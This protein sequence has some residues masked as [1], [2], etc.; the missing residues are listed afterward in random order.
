MNSKVFSRDGVLLLEIGEENRDVVQIKDIPERI[1]GA[2]LAAEDDNFYAHHG[3]DYYGLARAFIANIKGGGVV[4]GG[5]TITQQVAKL[6]LLSKEKT[7]SRKVKDI[8]LAQKIEKQFSK[9]EILFLYL[10]QVYLGGGYYGVKA[11]L[12]GYFDKDLKEAS[13]AESALIAGLLVA[14]GKYSPYVNPKFAK[15]RQRYV[16]KRMHATKKITDEEYE[17]ALI[18]PITMKIRNVNEMKGG[19]FTDWV[20]QQLLES[21][22][23]EEFLNKGYNVVTTIDWKLQEK[24]QET[25]VKRTKELDKRQGFKGKNRNIPESDQKQILKSH[26]EKIYKEA[27]QFFTFNAEGENIYEYHLDEDE[28]EKII[29]K[30]DDKKENLNTRHKGIVE[31]GSSEDDKLIQFIKK[32]KSYQAIVTNVSDSAKMIYAT[33]AGVKVMI[34]LDG[35]SWAHERKL[36]ENERYFSLITKPSTILKPGDEIQVLIKGDL[37]SPQKYLSSEFKKKYTDPQL[38]KILAQEKFLLADL[39][40]EAEVEGALVAIDPNNGHVLALVGGGNFNKSQFN[41]AVQAMRQPGSSFK[42]FIYAAGLENGFA[43]SSILLDTPQS[44]G[45]VDDSLSWKPKNYDNEFMGQMTYRKA[46]EVSRNIP[47]IKILQDIGIQNMNDFSNRLGMQVTLPKD[48]SIALGSFGISLVE[49]ARAYTIFPNA[50]KISPLQTI[51]SIKDSSGKKYP[52]PTI[53]KNTVS[54][55]KDEPESTATQPSNPF[56]QNL[57]ESQV[58]DKRLAYIMTQLLR[59][60]ITSGTATAARG[61][62][63]NIAGKTGT[64][65]NYVDALFV[66]FS[67][68]IVVATWTGFDDNRPMGY[69]ETGGKTALPMWMDFMETAIEKLGA[70]EFIYPEG[71][72]AKNINKN[73]GK[74]APVGSPESITEYF[75]LG[76]ESG[77]KAQTDPNAPAD[78]K[79][80]EDDDYYINQ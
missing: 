8:I 50:G 41:R 7:F 12:R 34:P 24:A 20:R 61:L 36:D 66:G 26:R 25:V 44:L 38:N 43:A 71:V 68:K 40:Q 74:E 37:D 28:F 48:M 80:I 79:T 53:Y 9:E 60:V 39:D 29:D 49:L 22:G 59:G 10:N 13:V 31:I 5:S 45:G 76:H 78:T 27:S 1:V 72:V 23:T 11:A 47:T 56:L 58:Y 65:N 77:I 42:P 46:L 70:P 33:L 2:F 75:V 17:K 15:M 69:G 54:K 73:T 4:Q 67:Q 14:P 63:S 3:V 57:N 19:H 16:L 30:Q 64:T 18:E 51:I 6:L 52:V 35:F 32:N 62:S 21:L 55:V